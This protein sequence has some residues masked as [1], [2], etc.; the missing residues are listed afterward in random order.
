MSLQRE[1]RGEN[2]KDISGDNGQN[3][4]QIDKSYKHRDPKTSRNHKHKNSKKKPKKPKTSKKK[5][6]GISVSNC[7]KPVMKRKSQQ[8]PENNEQTWRTLI[9]RFI[10]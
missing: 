9:S 7:L 3:F 8:S 4:P 5:V 2:R 10:I 6:Q 1:T